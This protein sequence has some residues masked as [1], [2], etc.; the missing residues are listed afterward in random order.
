MVSPAVRAEDCTGLLPF[1]DCTLDQD[2]T[3]PLGID[4]DVTLTIGADV[5]INHTINGNTGVTKGDIATDGGGRAII[6]QADL[7]DVHSIENMTIG[8]GDVWYVSGGANIF[9]EQLSPIRLNGSTF[10]VAPGSALSLISAGILG[11]AGDDSLDFISGGQSLGTTGFLGRAGEDIDLGAGNDRFLYYQ[12]AG[13]V[14]GADRIRMRNG[15]NLFGLLGS[16]VGSV[17]VGDFSSGVDRDTIAF[18]SGTTATFGSVSSSVTLGLGNDLIDFAS[19]AGLA[20]GT[21]IAGTLDLG[22]DDDTIL[23]SGNAVLTVAGTFTA[24]DGN[25]TI[26]FSSGGLFDAA[27]A[28][29]DMGDGDDTIRFESVAFNGARG[30]NVSGGTFT[31]GDGNDSLIFT[32]SAI[33]LNATGTT[34]D[35]GAGD[36]AITFLSSS[37][38]IRFVSGAG[39]L[40]IDGGTGSDTITF[41]SGETIIFGSASGAGS[42]VNMETLDAGN[43]TLAYTGMIDSTAEIINFSSAEFLGGAT[44]IAATLTGDAAAETVIFSSGATFSGTANMGDGIDHVLFRSGGV[45]SGTVN[46]DGGD[47]LFEAG[48]GAV[49]GGTVD[50]GAGSNTLTFLSGAATVTGGIINFSSGLIGTG[51]TVNIRDSGFITAPL[52]GT[53]T[54]QFGSAGSTANTFTLTASVDQVNLEVLGDTLGTGGFALGSGTPLRGLRVGPGAL[55]LINDDVDLGD[56]AADANGTLFVDGTARIAPTATVS[57]DRYDTADSGEFIFEINRSGGVTQVG[58]IQLDEAGQDIDFSSATGANDTFRFVLEAGSDALASDTVTFISA[59]AGG[60]ATAPED[61]NVFGSTILFDLSVLDANANPE[62]LELVV[63]QINTV[64]GLADSSSNAALGNVLITDLRNSTD[65]GINAIQTALLNSGSAG[66]FNDVLE[67]ARPILDGADMTAAR[68]VNRQT[69]GLINRRLSFL[70]DDSK[71]QTGVSTGNI[72]KE[73]EGWWQ[74]YGTGA[75]QQA[76]KTINGFNSTTYGLAVGLDR[77]MTENLVVGAGFAWGQTSARSKGAGDA[78][79]EVDSYQG[80][81]YADYDFGRAYVNGMTSYSYND[82]G[83]I[84]TSAAGTRHGTYHA[85]YFTTRA[86]TGYAFMPG[87]TRMIPKL[88]GTYG[89]YSPSSYIENGPGAQQI[90]GDRMTVAELGTG[91]D[92]DWLLKNGESSYFVPEVNLGYRYDFADAP[93]Q[94][95]TSFVAGG[96]AFTM[97]GYEPSP[98]SFDLGLGL[99]YF[100]TD[101]W[102]LLLRYDL[103]LKPDYV[104]QTGTVRASY[105]FYK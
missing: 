101:D 5:T 55:F 26:L 18:Y 84:K 13:S 83:T 92:M 60:T 57:A 1:A 87:K 97:L 53:G 90:T 6:Q 89:H 62:D 64:E 33:G 99:T 104:S 48:S 93:V 103:E 20:G 105:K 70:R 42:I 82:I 40:S 8:T 51:A 29:F 22:G 30:L 46:M 100:S 95:V 44:D 47:D 74:F 12:S 102:E 32:S 73:V 76:R 67:T 80:S 39:F 98:H 45:L 10:G 15:N 66:G 72:T 43:G 19:G 2:T 41:G 79:T 59:G 17:F 54:L 61:T 35:L 28:A 91:L 38:P 36:D 24:G 96:P 58:S 9:M 31:M 81:L 50:G 86:E 63:T 68:T 27:G 52:A 16:S 11:G 71:G 7:G 37:G 69:L 56:G 75:D 25:D 3:A 34:I 21:L 49:I 85:G 23:L 94:T 77:D 14:I 65:P 88:V 78:L 4:A